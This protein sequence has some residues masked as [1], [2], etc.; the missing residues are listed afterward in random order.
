M[1][2]SIDGD[3]KLTE[4]RA[5]FGSGSG[6][7]DRGDSPQAF[8]SRHRALDNPS[9]ASDTSAH[10]DISSDGDRVRRG[11]VLV[12]DRHRTRRIVFARINIESVPDD[13]GIAPNWGQPFV[14]RRNPAASA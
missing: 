8:S 14:G 4:Q 10:V 12:D 7:A 6:S 2:A 5:R 1:R 13:L 9:R 11:W 3:H